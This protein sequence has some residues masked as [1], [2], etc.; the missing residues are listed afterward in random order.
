M[1]LPFVGAEGGIEQAE[2]IDVTRMLI[3][4]AIDSPSSQFGSAPSVAHSINIYKLRFTVNL[5]AIFVL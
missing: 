4:C 5:I 1:T 3:G 2:L